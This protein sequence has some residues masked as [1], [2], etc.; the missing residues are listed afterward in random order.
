MRVLWNMIGEVIEG[1]QERIHYITKYNSATDLY[2]D[3]ME[4]QKHWGTEERFHYYE[5]II[6]TDIPRT[7]PLSKFLGHNSD[8]VVE[9]LR[10]FCAYSPVGYIQGMNILV[11][12]SLYIFP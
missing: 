2:R 10:R 12:A 5:H 7:F 3:Y 8:A 6:L 1:P 9:I 4:I 11:A